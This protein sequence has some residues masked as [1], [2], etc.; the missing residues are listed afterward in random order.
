MSNNDNM[1]IW[2]Q[3]NSPGRTRSGSIPFS[4]GRGEMKPDSI[5]TMPSGG[6]YGPAGQPVYDPDDFEVTDVYD[7][8]EWP[9]KDENPYNAIVASLEQGVDRGY[10][11][12]Y[13]AKPGSQSHEQW[14]DATISIGID[15]NMQTV[16]PAI[17]VDD[18][19]AGERSSVSPQIVQHLLSRDEQAIRHHLDKLN[20]EH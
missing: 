8:S 5:N 6:E 2:E 14:S 17:F 19:G 3:Y 13:G 12:F 1:L 9:T 15:D 18:D 4:D 11:V 20:H 7:F 10:V 16:N